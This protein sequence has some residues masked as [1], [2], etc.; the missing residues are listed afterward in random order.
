MGKH[1]VTMEI[2]ETCNVS[3]SEATEKPIKIRMRIEV[4]HNGVTL[5]AFQIATDALNA[6][7][8]FVK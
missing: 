4:Q 7:D 2:N 6:W 1:H 8:T 5:D 3:S